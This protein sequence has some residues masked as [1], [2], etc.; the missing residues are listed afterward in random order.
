M[1]KTGLFLTGGGGRGAFEIGVI[2]A[3]ERCEIPIDVIVGS[4]VGTMVGAAATYLSAEK[5][6]TRYKELTLERVLNLDEFKYK[7]LEGKKRT[8]TLWKDTILECAKPNPN[9]FINVDKIRSLLYGLL[10]EREIRN[11]ETE[12]GVTTTDLRQLKIKKIYK[13]DMP[14]GTIREH[15][16]SSIYLPIFQR[17]K[18]LGDKSYID[19]ADW[20]R[21]PLE[22]LNEKGC[23]NVYIVD[24]GTHWPGKMQRA[25]KRANLI[26]NSKVTLITMN[27]RMSILDFSEKSINE[28]YQNGYMVAMKKLRSNKTL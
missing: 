5:M 3:F 19:I 7:G 26:N 20:Q 8:L 23:D 12:F 25:I 9:L 1:S 2:K 6:L 22:M 18:L 16:L 13:E 4:S 28:A 21:Y 11:S 27:K 14:E 24:I 10:D 17:Q 15:I